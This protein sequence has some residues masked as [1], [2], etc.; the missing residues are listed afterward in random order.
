MSL[1]ASHG[2]APTAPYQRVPQPK[3]IPATALPLSEGHGGRGRAPSEGGVHDFLL[4]EAPQ[5]EQQ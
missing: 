3:T 5:E 2:R 4:A 1:P